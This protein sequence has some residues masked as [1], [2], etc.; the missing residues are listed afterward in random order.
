LELHTKKTNEKQFYEVFLFD[1]CE[2]IKEVNG[3]SLKKKEIADFIRKRNRTNKFKL[4]I[5]ARMVS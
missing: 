5:S 3:F 2:L 4:K 1:F